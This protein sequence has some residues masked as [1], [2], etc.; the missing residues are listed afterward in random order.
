MNKKLCILLIIALLPSLLH[1]QEREE[2]CVSFVPDSAALSTPLMP[3]LPPAAF[4][5]CNT[6]TPFGTGYWNLHEGLNAQIGAGV[7]VGWGKYNPFRGGSFFTD[8]S[9][10]Y[11]RPVTDRLTLAIGG[12]VSRFKFYGDPVVTG[13]VMALANYRFNEHLSGTIYG[14]Y[15]DN[16]SGNTAFH[17]LY[18]LDSFHTFNTLNSPYLPFLGR[19]AEIG[20]EMTYK[21]NNGVTVGVGYTQYIDVSSDVRPWLPPSRKNSTHPV[22]TPVY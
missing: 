22:F 2:E 20:A 12:T 6:F 13:S 7:T 9:L 1:A 8:I 19:C 17:S 18:S 4:S 10:I 21:F 3:D 16:L 5:L 15:H 11:A 14:A